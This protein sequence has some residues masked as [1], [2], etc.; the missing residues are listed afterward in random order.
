MAWN[1]G[2]NDAAN[3][4]NMAVGSGVL[5][6]RRAALIF[7]LF[8]TIGAILEG[9]RVSKTIGKGVVPN[10]DALM[11]LSAGLGAALWVT[12]ATREG[13]P[14]STTQSAVGAVLGIGIA[15]NLEGYDVPI[16]W[17]VVYHV[18]LSWITSPLGAIALA[19][20]LYLV[21]RAIG[22]IIDRKVNKGLSVKV[23]KYVLLGGLLFSA[24]AYGANDVGNAT[25]VYITAV[26]NITGYPDMTTMRLLALLGSVG[27]ALGAMTWGYRVINTV[28]FKVTR[29]DVISGAAA[30]LSNASIVYLFTRL[31]M[32]IST[33]HASVSS[34]IGVGIAKRGKLSDVN[35]KTVLIIL[36]GWLATLPVAAGIA[37]GIYLGLSKII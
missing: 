34:V 32:P 9:Y 36:I 11:A 3:P 24:Y 13:L 31:G 23:F 20:G 2:A 26:S 17:K 29:M 10:I 16:N 37:A 6:V 25:G 28:G 8:A 5:D 1:L 19:G 15:K 18:I 27:I 14:V 4:T 12:I 30:E 21:F 7:S 35:W 33:T 22:E